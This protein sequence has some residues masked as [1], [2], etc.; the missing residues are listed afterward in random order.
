MG[1]RDQLIG[2][3]EAAGWTAPTG[4]E[5]LW[6]YGFGGGAVSVPEEIHDGS[7]AW[8][9]LLRE[10]AGIERRALADVLAG[11]DAAG[12]AG[13]AP[14]RM[15]GR[16][17]LSPRCEMLPFVDVDGV[18]NRCGIVLTG[19]RT[20]WCSNECESVVRGEHDW[21]VARR[22]AVERDGGRCVR[23]GGDGSEQRPK[24]WYTVERPQAESL[25]GVRIGWRETISV[26]GHKLPW[27]EV[28]HIDPRVGRGYLWGCHN[29]LANLETLCHG[30]HVVETK[31][32]AAQR[33]G[34]SAA[35]HS[36]VDDGQL[37]FEDAAEVNAPYLQRI[38]IDTYA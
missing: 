23:C 20:K 6:R 29:H 26:P 35:A 31:R 32:Q 25:F 16:Y 33:R 37:S 38:S 36:G 22:L 10:V 9:M 4:T 1:A 24:R 5:L 2:Y 8:G 17:N 34:A 11:V 15:W 7:M 3:L 21:S 27:L 18:C 19:R 12:G 30:C 13:A 28:N 14:L